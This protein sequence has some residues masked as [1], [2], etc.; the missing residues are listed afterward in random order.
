MDGIIVGNRTE[1]R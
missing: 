1:S